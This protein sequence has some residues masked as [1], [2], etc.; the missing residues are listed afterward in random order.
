MG[1]G[2]PEVLDGAF[3]AL[4]VEKTKSL[5]GI[6]AE[7]SRELIYHVNYVPYALS[8]NIFQ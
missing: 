5:H 3:P 1:K 7:L 8:F 4:G 6:V 2:K